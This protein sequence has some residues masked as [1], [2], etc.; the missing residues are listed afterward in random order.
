LCIRDS[1]AGLDTCYRYQPDCTIAGSPRLGNGRLLEDEC[2]QIQSA[3]AFAIIAIV[4]SFAAVVPIGMLLLHYQSHV[5]EGSSAGVSGGS[6]SGRGFCILMFC[7]MTLFFLVLA[8]VCAAVALSTFVAKLKSDGFNYGLSFVLII[9]GSILEGIGTV[10]LP[11]SLWVWFRDV[12]LFV[13]RR[14]E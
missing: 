2:H 11:S 8:T 7:L 3:Q 1:Q 12:P 9:V 4:S 6:A 14:K 10:W 13:D 5:C